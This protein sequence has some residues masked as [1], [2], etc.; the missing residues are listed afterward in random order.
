MNADGKPLRW[1]GAGLVRAGFISW[2]A[3][4][5]LVVLDITGSRLTLRFR[6]ALLARFLGIETL[7]AVPDDNLRIFPIQNDRTWKGIDFRLPERSSF[8]FYTSHREQVLETLTRA[9]FVVSTD[10]EV[11]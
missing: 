6:P 10:A 2:Q 7:T 8:R 3:T 9:G 4:T 11:S 1:S 5:P